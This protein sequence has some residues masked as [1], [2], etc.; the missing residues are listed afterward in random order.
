MVARARIEPTVDGP[1]VSGPGNAV[2]VLGADDSAPLVRL[3]PY[4][5]ELI[6]RGTGTDGNG[7]RG[8]WGFVEVPAGAAGPLELTVDGELADRIE[9]RSEPEAAPVDSSASVAIALATFEPPAELFRGQIESIRAQT[10]DDWICVISDDA[11]SDERFAEMRRVLGDDARFVLRRNETRLGF[12][13]NFERALLMVPPAAGHVALCDQ[14]DVWRPEKLERL[15]AEIGDAQLA[16][17]DTRIVEP[18]GR[19]ASPTYWVG[20]SNN[21]TNFA[22]LLFANT[23]TGAASL[24]RR[25]LLDDALP[26]PNAPGPVYHDHWIALVALAQGEIRYLDEPLYD[27]VQH[28]EAFLGHTAAQALDIDRPSLLRRARGGRERYAR[29]LRAWRRQYFEEYCRTQIL[30]RVLRLRLGERLPP[31]RR[32]VLDRYRDAERS[33]LACGWLLARS[34][35]P[36][37]GRDETL[38]VERG[39]LRGILWRRLLPIAGRRPAFPAAP[40][41]LTDHHADP[42][43]RS[44]ARR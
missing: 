11:S 10:H 39:L 18:S 23:V 12:Y 2:F 1:L 36:W 7:G 42:P 41:R 33:P 4:E 17:S 29:A 44:R 37:F 19:V 22:S 13:R 6:G 5:A 20:R 35:R 9:V 40:R 34:F 3:G 30:A 8:F 24:F 14:D 25:E 28:G 26:F 27:Y 31:R 16:Y 32:R 21:C 43:T 15:A 38:A